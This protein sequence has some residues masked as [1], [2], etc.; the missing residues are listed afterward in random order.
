MC[1]VKDLYSFLFFFSLFFKKY[2]H[3]ILS[4]YPSWFELWTLDVKNTCMVDKIICYH[5]LAC[6]FL[7]LS[8]FV[9]KK[10]VRGVIEPLMLSVC[11]FVCLFVCLPANIKQFVQFNLLSF[12]SL[13]NLKVISR[14]LFVYPSNTEL[15]FLLCI[16][17]RF[18]QDFPL[19][20]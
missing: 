15:W 18:S 14:I 13:Y 17:L 9:D 3:K 19:F 11:S 20:P 16:M 2:F 10:A 5:S 6:Q 7:F 1:K 12:F 4:L 8:F